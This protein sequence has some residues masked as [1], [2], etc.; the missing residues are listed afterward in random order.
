MSA[1]PHPEHRSTA[2]TTQASMLYMIL[3]F[4]PEILNDEQA[5]MREI[6][7]KHFPDNWVI[8]Y[9]MGFTVDLSVQVRASVSLR[10]RALLHQL[11]L[12]LPVGSHL[13]VGWLQRCPLGAQQFRAA[14]QHHLAVEAPLGQRRSLVEGAREQPDGGRAGARPSPEQQR[15]AHVDG[16]RVQRHHSLVDAPYVVALQTTP[17]T[18]PPLGTPALRRLTVS[19]SF[20]TIHA[21]AD[22][23]CLNKKVKEL[24][25]KGFDHAKLLVLILKTAQFEFT[26]KRLYQELLD[27]KEERWNGCKKEGI[28][29]MN[30]LCTCLPPRTARVCRAQ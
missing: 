24:V 28:E 7:D 6:V 10:V 26:L 18:P 23:A 9:Y 3:Y 1:Y 8:A 2:L 11:T 17:P 27:T 22:S 12:G 14:K 30:D 25:M 16:T 4:V 13:A 19:C 29:R 5:I 21:L 20:D 15:Q